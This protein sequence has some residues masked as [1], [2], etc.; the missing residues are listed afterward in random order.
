M[1]N[2]TANFS[3]AFGLPLWYQYQMCASAPYGFVFYYGVKVFNLAVGAPCN[4]LV[5]WQIAAK[6]GDACTSDAFILNLAV[7]D[8]FFCLMVP[9]ELLNTLLLDD[10]RIWYLQRFSYGVKDAGVLFLVCVCVDRHMAVVHPVLFARVRSNKFRMGVSAGVWAAI[11]AYALAKCVLGSMRVNGVFS[12]VVLFALAVM[13]LCNAS[14]VWVLRRS[15]GGKEAMHPAKKKALK[16]VLVALAIIVVNY[17]PP[18]LM[19]FAP[20]Y[21]RMEFRCQIRISVYSIMD[22]SCSVEPLLYVTKTECVGGWCCR[23][24]VART[25][26]PVEV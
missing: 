23:R 4:G 8:A 22:L 24:C 16:M 15:V 9:A 11:A 1:F 17:L 25:P 14:V 3:D 21:T 19:P 18:V 10:G 6:K 5:I 20:Y 7:L 13:V 2:T 26:P 12:G